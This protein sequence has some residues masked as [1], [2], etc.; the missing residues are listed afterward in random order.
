LKAKLL[1]NAPKEVKM[2]QQVQRALEDRKYKLEKD[3]KRHK[4]KKEYHMLSLAIMQLRAVIHQ[5]ELLARASY[6]QL[7]KLWL[8]FIHGLS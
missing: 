5:L 4:R 2:R 3:I 1:K 7:K 8:R 6:D